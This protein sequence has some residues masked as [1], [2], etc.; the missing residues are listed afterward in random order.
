[1]KDVIGAE[2]ELR[3]A[4]QQGSR[5]NERPIRENILYHLKDVCFLSKSKGEPLNVLR[6]DYQVGNRENSFW[7]QQC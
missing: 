5:G 4:E 6:N 2:C 7:I 1:M 3:R